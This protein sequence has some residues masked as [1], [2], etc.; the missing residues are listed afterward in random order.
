MAVTWHLIPQ[1]SP[2][3]LRDGSQSPFLSLVEVVKAML[4]QGREGTAE[5]LGFFM[6]VHEAL[7]YSEAEFSIP[8]T[9]N[10]CHLKVS[11]EQEQAAIPL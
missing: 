5:E 10:S 6:G 4:P 11:S 3:Q 8:T 9:R 2:E 7:L 1:S